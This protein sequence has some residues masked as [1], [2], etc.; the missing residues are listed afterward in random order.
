MKRLLFPLWLMLT[1]WMALSAQGAYLQNVPQ[2][3]TQPDGTKIHCFA[4]G[5]EFYNWLHDENG[6]TIVR[7]A[8]GYWVYAVEA[9]GRLAPSTQVVGTAKPM[10]PSLRPG[11][12]I[13]NEEYVQRRAAFF[14]GMDPVAAPTEGDVNNLCIFIRF[15]DQAEFTRSLSFYDGILN[16]TKQDDTSMRSYYHEVSYEKLTIRTTFYSPPAGFSY[17]DTHPRSYY[18]PYDAAA[19]PHGYVDFDDRKEREHTLLKNAVDA[20]KSQVPTSLV[21]DRDRD[22]NVDN[23]CFIIRGSKDEWNG[24]LWAHWWALFTHHVEINGRRVYS[25]TFH[26][27]ANLGLGV[28]C[29]EM[30]HSLGA[31]DL[32][33]YDWG[34]GMTP[35]GPWDLMQWAADPPQHMGAYMKFRY[36]RWITLP[37]IDIG[38]AGT[39]TLS[40]LTSST[41]NAYRLTRTWDTP[42]PPEHYVFEYRR[43]AEAGKFEGSLPGSGLLVYRINGEADG[44]GNRDSPD[45]VYVYRPR[46]T[47]TS[48]GSVSQAH[49]GVDVK[50]TCINDKT[51]PSGFLSDGSAGGLFVADIGHAEDTIDFYV[52]EPNSLSG[53]IYDT[54]GGPLS[55]SKNPYWVV[56]NVT[57]PSG[58]TLNVENGTRVYFGAGTKLTAQGTINCQSGSEWTRLFALSGYHTGIKGKGQI[59]MTNGGAIKLH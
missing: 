39:Y 3:L 2:T 9:T 14:E 11:L 38:K 26:P 4:S 13:S 36:G 57:T 27:D 37:G 55:S 56:E 42:R 5:D 52:G 7:D 54:D 29:H 41:N 12:K 49:F 10:A 43:K 47:T 17:R 28:L 48:D 1:F 23:I 50:R 46:G 30:F 8:S 20:V 22:G 51:D 19:N 44:E 31:K 16:S 45:E 35:V 6:F 34:E 58:R 18:L 59:R 40:P 53:L 32:Y 21:I 33:H 15:S 24:M 25:Y